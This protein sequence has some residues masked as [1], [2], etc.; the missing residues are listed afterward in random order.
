MP[1]LS[2]F[3]FPPEPRRGPRRGSR[4]GLCDET[5]SESRCSSSVAATSLSSKRSVPRPPSPHPSSQLLYILIKVEWGEV[6]IVFFVH[7][8]FPLLTVRKS[9][10]FFA[11]LTSQN[12]QSHTSLSFSPCHTF[13]LCFIFSFYASVVC[14]PSLVTFYLLALL[15]PPASVFIFL[16]PLTLLSVLFLLSSLPARPELCM[17]SDGPDGRFDRAALR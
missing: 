7:F 9:V 12:S 4:Y 14:L 11:P 1:F 5:F 15:F 13:F 17:C 2:L 10:F 3:F 8:C 6:W 16:F